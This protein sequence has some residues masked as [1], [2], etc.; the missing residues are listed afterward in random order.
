MTHR[1]HKMNLILSVI[2]ININTVTSQLKQSS[3]TRFL[4][5]KFLKQ[6]HTWSLKIRGMHGK[7]VSVSDKV[8]EG[9]FE[10]QY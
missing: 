1:K 8:G 3:T 10:K 9:K 5:G 7:D 4:Q 2:T 6:T